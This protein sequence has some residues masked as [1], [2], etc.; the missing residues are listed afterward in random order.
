[1]LSHYSAPPATAPQF[2]LRTTL[3]I[4]AACVISFAAG[5]LLGGGQTTL[6][7]DQLQSSIL[8]VDADE[9]AAVEKMKAGKAGESTGSLSSDL[10]A[11]SGTIGGWFDDGSAAS[12]TQTASNAASTTGTSSA[13]NSLLGGATNIGTDA[14][15]GAG[16][17]YLGGGKDGAKKGA[18][19]MAA[20]S[21]ANQSG[22]L[23]ASN[24]QSL[25]GRAVDGVSGLFGSTEKTE[26]KSHNSGSVC[27]SPEEASAWRT[28]NPV[29]V[30]E[31]DLRKASGISTGGKP[32]TIANL[33][34][35]K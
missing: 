28:A 25:T 10:D 12:T 11:V 31:I 13:I 18:L 6:Q 30:E 34:E 1:M 32:E 35:L 21:A 29:P 2:G 19:G 7:A 26:E 23:G 22:M 8:T 33:A 17:G 16:L 27:L 15:V 9:A 24:G 4:A 20:L 5:L 3:S 14:A